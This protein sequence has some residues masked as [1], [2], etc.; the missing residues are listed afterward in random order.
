MDRAIAQP[1]FDDD[2][3]LAGAQSRKIVFVA[4]CETD[5]L[6]FRGRAATEISDRSMFDLAVLAMRLPQQIAGVG[7]AVLANVRDVDVYCG[8]ESP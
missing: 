1:L 6:D 2:L 8:Y 5:G 4:Q 7:F 3:R